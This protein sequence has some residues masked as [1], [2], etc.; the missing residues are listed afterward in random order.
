[1]ETL[2]NIQPTGTAHLKLAKQKVEHL[3]NLKK[4]TTADIEGLTPNRAPAPRRNLY[5]NA[6]GSWTGA[7]RD[8]FIDRIDLIIPAGPQRADIWEHNHS[9][10]SSAV[11]RL[12]GQ[13]WPDAHPKTP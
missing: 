3:L 11:S 12:I 10:I 7:E 4:I 6:A 9:A 8:S 2:T 5:P 1:M 13:R